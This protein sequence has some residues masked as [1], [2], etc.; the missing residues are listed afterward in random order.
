M[1][2][3]Y[4]EGFFI[5]K[6]IVINMGVLDEI[7]EGIDVNFLIKIIK[8]NYKWLKRKDIDI[9]GIIYIFFLIFIVNEDGKNFVV[10]NED[11]ILKYYESYKKV[12][13]IN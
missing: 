8:G 7:V 9:V 13:M 3:V 11:N 4:N 12:Y 10:N 2:V 6:I 5:G 1:V